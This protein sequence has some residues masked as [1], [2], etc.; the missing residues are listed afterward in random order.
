M[1]TERLGCLSVPYHFS[2]LLNCI[3]TDSAPSAYLNS[4]S[5]ILP[6]NKNIWQT[7]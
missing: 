3:A 6:K 4:A 2:E 7:I 1:G 5:T